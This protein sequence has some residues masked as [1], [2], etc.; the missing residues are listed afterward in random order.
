MKP[1]IHDTILRFGAV[2][3][4]ALSFALVILDEIKRVERRATDVFGPINNLPLLLV[5]FG[6]SSV[7]LIVFWSRSRRRHDQ[8]SPPQESKEPASQSSDSSNNEM[9]HTH[10]TADKN[11]RKTHK[12]QVA[13]Q[14]GPFGCELITDQDQLISNSSR[15]QRMPRN[16]RSTKPSISPKPPLEMA[17][18][19]S[20]Q[21]PGASHP[22]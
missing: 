6:V 15:I 14:S 7:W 1:D 5:A 13:T 12:T 9:E 2:I 22:T 20:Q 11:K 8:N 17:V 3:S 18:R 21:R 10:P 4:T 19:K 16:R